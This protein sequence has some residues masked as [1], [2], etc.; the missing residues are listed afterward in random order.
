MQMSFTKI[1]PTQLQKKHLKKTSIQ[2]I[3]S[4]S[5]WQFRQERILV[6]LHEKSKI[7]TKNS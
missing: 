6:K 2:K 3:A 7:R 4:N 5:W 1:F